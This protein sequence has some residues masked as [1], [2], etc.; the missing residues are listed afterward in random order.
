M[1]CESVGI[2]ENQVNLIQ[3]HIID[4]FNKLALDRSCPKFKH[5]TKTFFFFSMEKSY[6]SQITTLYLEKIRV[7]LSFSFYLFFWKRLGSTYSGP[8]NHLTW[9]AQNGRPDRALATFNHIMSIITFHSFFKQSVLINLFAWKMVKQG[10][11]IVLN[12]PNSL[13]KD[14]DMLENYQLPCS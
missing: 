1:S 6:Y 4:W 2:K 12:F 8:K 9:Q 7:I 14:E 5:S 3:S 10:L 11:Y 13:G